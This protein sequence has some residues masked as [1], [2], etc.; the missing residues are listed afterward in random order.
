MKRYTQHGAEFG[1]KGQRHYCA[2][3]FCGCVALTGGLV[4]YWSFANGVAVNSIVQSWLLIS[5]LPFCIPIAKG[6][7]RS[8]KKFELCYPCSCHDVPRKVI[9]EIY[10][11]L[12]TGFSPWLEYYNYQMHIYIM[13]CCLRWF[14]ETTIA[15]DV[16][17]LLINCEK[18]YFIAP[19]YT[20]IQT[21]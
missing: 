18:Q 9:H 16:T 17:Y 8:D 5:G 2:N 6:G 12:M 10:T 1:F 4:H 3:E 14:T 20:H 11:T 7:E 15:E 19:S 13:T 21:R